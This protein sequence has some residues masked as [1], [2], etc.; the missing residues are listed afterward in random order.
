MKKKAESSREI[1]SKF[2]M[3]CL[4]CDV[5][6]RM[7]FTLKRGVVAFRSNNEITLISINVL[8]TFFWKHKSYQNMKG[9][10]I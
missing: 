3:P 1:H 4:L 5:W 8:R 10:N 7:E 2:S 9:R 6:H